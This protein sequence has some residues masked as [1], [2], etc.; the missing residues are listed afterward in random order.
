MFKKTDKNQQSPK[1]L[2]VPAGE[3][4][5]NTSFMD[6]P[7]LPNKVASDNRL[8]RSSDE[9]RESL[10][11]NDRNITE[12]RELQDPIRRKMN[13]DEFAFDVLPNL[14][15]VPGYH[16]CWLSTKNDYDSIHTRMRMGYVPLEVKDVPGYE[17][18]ELK[19]GEYSGFIGHREMLAFKLPNERFQHYMAHMHHHKPLQEEE[20]IHAMVKNLQHMTPGIKVNIEQDIEAASG[21][22]P[23]KKPV[24]TFF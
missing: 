16:V 6:M 21:W 17:Q 2:N 10:A 1:E 20:N 13:I 8:V 5:Q 24:P 3:G 23:N 15:Q 18:L 4:I 9:A 12:D 14:P 19:S 7:P 22:T 11:M